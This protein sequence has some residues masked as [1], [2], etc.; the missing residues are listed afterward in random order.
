MVHPMRKLCPNLDNEDGLETVLEV[1][2]PEEMFGEIGSSATH[3][4]RNLRN[5]MR[6]AQRA[7]KSSLPLSCNDHVL[8]LLKMVGSALIPFNVQSDH[9]HALA[10]PVR[11]C[12]IVCIFFL[13]CIYVELEIQI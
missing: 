1:P 9:D 13:V 6:A 2:V 12:F 7:D 8:F 11:D 5:R 4:W 3:G 10:M